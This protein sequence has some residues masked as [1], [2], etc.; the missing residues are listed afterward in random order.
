[1]NVQKAKKGVLFLVVGP[2]GVGKDSLINYA[3]N[4]F[5]EDTSYLFPVRHISRPPDQ[6]GEIY[7]SLGPEEFEENLTAGRFALAWQAHGFM[8][9]IGKEIEDRLAEGT[10]VIV[11]VSRTVIE[12]ARSRFAP[13]VIVQIAADRETLARRLTERGREVT[14]EINA[15]LDRGDAIAVRG[16]DVVTIQND[17]AVER[18][19]EEFVAILRRIAGGA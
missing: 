5:R 1:M 2:S 16:D 8:Y 9:G 19:G 13:V 10:H 12:A 17:G 11:N 7:R 14:E 15:R 4:R 18:A 6:G 3:R